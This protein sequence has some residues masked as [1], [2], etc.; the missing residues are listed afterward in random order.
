LEIPKKKL[1]NLIKLII[2][3]KKVEKLGKIISKIIFPNTKN[4]N[5]YI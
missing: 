4:Y 2:P 5:K 3:E 1:I